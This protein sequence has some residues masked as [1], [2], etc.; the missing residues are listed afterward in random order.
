MQPRTN[1]HVI[2]TAGFVLVAAV[3]FVGCG[4]S[5]TAG[6]STTASVSEP[7][8]STIVP[9]ATVSVTIDNFAFSPA[10]LD[11]AAGTTV[12]WTNEQDV[13]HTVTADDGSFDSGNIASGATFSHTF[14]AAG[15][16]AY[17]CAIHPTMK[18]S[19]TVTG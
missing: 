11:V 18:A 2:G 13:T 14:D 5:T 8:G 15:T 17:H 6:P 19:I 3:A 7:P 12:T 9:S 10:T 4:S 16:I 1:R